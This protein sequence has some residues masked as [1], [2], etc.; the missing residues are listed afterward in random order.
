MQENL[1]VKAD[2]ASTTAWLRSPLIR[3]S[4]QL[5]SFQDDFAQFLNGIPI[6]PLRD[7]PIQVAGSVTVID[8]MVLCLGET[9]PT[10]CMH[11]T[12]D[13]MHEQIV[14]AMTPAAPA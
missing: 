3:T 12:R 11:V 6:E 5:R 4:E 9:S 13:D 14:L 1:G 8:Q 7:G 10:R 2:F